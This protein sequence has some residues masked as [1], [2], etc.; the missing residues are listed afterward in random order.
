MKNFVEVLKN[1]KLFNN[2]SE[3]D[4]ESMIN[5]LL[6]KERK[7][8]KGDFILRAGDRLTAVNMVAEGAVHI[9][10]ED[11]WGNQSILTEIGVGELFGETYA[12]LK[13]IPLQVNVVAV[14]VSTVLEI[15]INRV[16]AVCTDKCKFYSR[17][18]EN[19]LS[20]VAGKNLMLTNKM[21]CMVQRTTRN[22]I[23]SYLSLQSE[24]N[25]SS[26]FNIP[27]NRQQLADYLAVDRSAMSKELC[28]LRDEGILS[29]SKNHFELGVKK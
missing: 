24:K 18:I 28:R 5:C 6:I 17:L 1:S 10:K 19:L 21:E 3:S 2:I 22:K 4:I 7:Y 29:F 16:L 25:N 15:D 20:V 26:Q 14:K 8:N 23:M 12:C 11:Y 27:F 9:L 13:N